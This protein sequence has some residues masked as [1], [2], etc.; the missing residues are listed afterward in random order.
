MFALLVES[1]A[2]PVLTESDRRLLAISGS[3]DP[4]PS[5]PDTTARPPI[6]SPGGRG[7]AR[8]VA[9]DPE[10]RI[11]IGGEAGMYNTNGNHW[12]D[13]AVARL[14]GDAPDAPA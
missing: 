3:L 1:S 6:A 4:P 12:T 10:T 7:T 11:L 9:I 5:T 14:L 2:S 13:F 8:G